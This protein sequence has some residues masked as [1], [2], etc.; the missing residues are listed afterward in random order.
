MATRAPVTFDCADPNRLASFWAEALGYI[1]Q[2]PPPGFETWEAFGEQMGMPAD[3]RDAIA[4]AVDP[5]GAGPR[6]LFLRVPEGKA[7]KNRVHLDL[8]VVAPGMPMD[9]RRSALAART[10]ELKA[11]GATE[12]G[13]VEEYGQ[14]WIVMADPEGNEFCI[15]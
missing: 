5:E 1:L 12:V 13:P 3:A 10:G 8:H 14:Y 7:G 9:E 2:P 6:L 15:A 4:A 11:L